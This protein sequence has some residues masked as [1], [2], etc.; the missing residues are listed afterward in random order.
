MYIKKLEGEFQITRPFIFPELRES[1]YHDI[2]T[3]YPKFSWQN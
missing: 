3:R 1:I 2:Q